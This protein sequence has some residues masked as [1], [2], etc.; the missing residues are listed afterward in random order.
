[1]SESATHIARALELTP[2][3]KAYSL[4]AVVSRGG[5]LNC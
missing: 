1:M 5:A 2:A 3:E 4:F